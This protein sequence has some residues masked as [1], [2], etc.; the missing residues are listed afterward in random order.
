MSA[1]TVSVFSRVKMPLS[2]AK[3]LAI[4]FFEGPTLK[5]AKSLLGKTL[6]RKSGAKL[7][8]GTI[9]ET[10][11]YVGP[12][13]KA[14]HASRGITPRTKI[15][16]GDCGMIYVYLIYGMYYC[17]N[18][19]TGKRGYPAAVLIRGVL[20]DGLNLNGPGKITR[21]FNIN[22]N[23]NSKKLCKNSCLWIENS[24]E[25]DPKEIKSGPRIG[26]NYAGIWAKKP[27]RFYLKQKEAI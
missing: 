15:M 2:M 27:R 18:I 23:L 17:L 21:H 26:V 7:I 6:V 9:T 11:A 1:K 4:K 25:I 24:A 22:K 3:I 13:D 10:E 20:S 16:F 19:V 8:R 5:V 14:S 12:L